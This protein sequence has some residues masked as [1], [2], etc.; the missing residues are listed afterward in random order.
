MLP[1]FFFALPWRLGVLAVRNFVLV[2]LAALAFLAV[3]FLLFLRVLRV[4][5]GSAFAFNIAR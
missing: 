1:Y 5:C 3:R 2:F 4:L